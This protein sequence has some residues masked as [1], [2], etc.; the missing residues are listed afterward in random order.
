MV[1]PTGHAMADSATDVINKLQH[2]II[3][4]LQN[5]DNLSF[6]WR[7]ESFRQLVDQ[8]HDMPF[9]SRL[10]VHRAWQEL[11]EAQRASL[12]E[13]LARLSAATYASRFKRYSEQ[14]FQI[15]G[16]Q[17]QPRGRKLVNAKLVTS[18][19]RQVDFDYLLHRV[20]DE[21]LIVNIIVDGVSD[22]ALKRAEYSGYVRSGGY[23]E[24]IESLDRQIEEAKQ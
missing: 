24:L 1:L 11:D 18:D 23:L 4:I 8:T 13:R 19:G 2:G 10:T 7:Y 16:E 20:E 5:P 9:I 21:W 14:Q 17:D 12:V 15:L 22:L 3:S 6:L